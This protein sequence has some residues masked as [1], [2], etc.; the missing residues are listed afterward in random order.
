MSSDITKKDEDSNKMDDENITTKKRRVDDPTNSQPSLLQLPLSDFVSVNK[1][2]G[3]HTSSLLS[4]V[5]SNAFT[6]NDDNK[7]QDT[8]ETMTNHQDSLLLFQLPPTLS[9]HTFLQATTTSTTTSDNDVQILIR[10]NTDN[11]N[12]DIKDIPSITTVGAISLDSS[13]NTTIT[14]TTTTTHP[15]TMIIPTLGKTLALIR[16]ETSNRY[17][18]VP[19]QVPIPSTSS[20]SYVTMN[21]R[22]FHE[23][24]TFIIES[25]D[26]SNQLLH[27]SKGKQSLLNYLK[28]F[29]FPIQ[30][31]GCTMH[32]LIQY[33]TCTPMEIQNALYH[34][35]AFTFPV[36]NEDATTTTTTTST[37]GWIQ[38]EYF[39]FTIQ[40]ILYTLN[41]DFN[42]DMKD[43]LSP[44]TKNATFT[45]YATQGIHLTTFIQQAIQ[46]LNSLWIHVSLSTNQSYSLIYHV[47]FHYMKQHDKKHQIQV[48]HHDVKGNDKE[49][50][51]DM[52]KN[53][54]EREYW[55]LNTTKVATWV[56]KILFL[57]QTVWDKE[58][59]I[60]Q[61]H[62]H[63]P[64]VGTVYQP[65][66]SILRGLCI[67]IHKQDKE[68]H[69]DDDDEVG[70]DRNDH[71][72]VQIL[73]LPHESL[74]IQPQGRFQ[75]LF[76]IQSKWKWYH[77]E[78]Y[79]V[80]MMDGWKE[81]E[82]REVD[83][84]G[85]N[86]EKVQIMDAKDPKVALFWMKYANEIE[87]AKGEVWY[88]AKK[89]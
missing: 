76:Q 74:P 17:V 37:Y 16:V 26:I 53:S 62:S 61:W 85:K 43:T 10:D 70:E 63:I 87:D 5:K 50:I 46:H 67:E 68:T 36:E 78:P 18:L 15:C 71:H 22:L 7:D 3:N 65:D 6:S 81:E 34:V 88:V 59:F 25:I 55:I 32:D 9:L 72:H 51:H 84:N 47:L 52:E 75:K 13:K 28:Q 89:E 79:I 29:L 39:Y 41:D 35:H 20:S 27:T 69:G 54:N 8:I 33:F 82:E 45:K 49:R 44:S 80:S 2:A 12:D 57:Q 73:Y 30:T 14:T 60:N 58:K 24:D 86:Q 4:K 66:V 23:Q 1:P 38:E 40:A 42:L 64:G 31:Q 56:A 19:P 11:D 77:L 21:A 83:E 48:D